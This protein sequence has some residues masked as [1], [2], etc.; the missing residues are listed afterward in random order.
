[1]LAA[2]RS[3][4][5]KQSSLGRKSVVSTA[6]TTFKQ[7]RLTVLLLTI[8]LHCVTFM[9]I[10][11]SILSQ[12]YKGS[13]V[14]YLKCTC[15]L[16]QSLSF[17]LNKKCLVYLL[18]T[19][20]MLQHLTYATSTKVCRLFEHQDYYNHGNISSSFICKFLGQFDRYKF[21]FPF[22]EPP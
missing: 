17:P 14:R 2:V 9:T 22:V 15:A 21:P 3:R 11:P 4:A 13:S 5:A 19:V 16:F 1:M 12:D 7:V 10:N 8:I 6:K 18:N 20:M